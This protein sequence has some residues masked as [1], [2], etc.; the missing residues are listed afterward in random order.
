MKNN[1]YKINDEK[2]VIRQI[3]ENLIIL[4]IDTGDFISVD[5]T[6]KFILEKIIEGKDEGEILCLLLNN[7]NCPDK[8]EVLADLHE[9]MGELR[10]RGII[11]E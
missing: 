9:Y 1:T 4:D 6:A 3:E 11:F 10:D 8:D 2:V 5:T 7:Y